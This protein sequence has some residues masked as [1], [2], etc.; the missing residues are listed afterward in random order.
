MML[1]AQDF[2]RLPVLF[3]E[4]GAGLNAVKTRQGGRFKV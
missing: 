1:A 4:I 2:Q 3:G